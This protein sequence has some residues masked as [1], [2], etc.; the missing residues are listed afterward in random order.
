MKSS[1]QKQRVSSVQ[2]AALRTYA[3]IAEILAKKEDK[4]IGKVRVQQLCARA[5]RKIAM[6][7]RGEVEAA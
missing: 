1:H 3:E 5:E 2:G 6:A 7:L 4:R